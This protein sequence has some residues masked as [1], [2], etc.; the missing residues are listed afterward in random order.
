VLAA[1]RGVRS[2]GGGRVRP[3]RADLLEAVALAPR[4]G[5]GPPA[6]QYTRLAA[7]GWEYVGPVASQFKTFGNGDQRA[8][9]FVAFRRAKK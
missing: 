6:V 9:G 3:G 5:P 4:S 2:L 1:E 8:T 7:D